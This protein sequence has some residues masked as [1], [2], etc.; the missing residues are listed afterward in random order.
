MTPEFSLVFSYDGIALLQ[1]APHGWGRV[2]TV[3]LDSA[4]ITADL[5]ALRAA[6]GGAGATRVKL[7]LPNDQIRYLKLDRTDATAA[8]VRA[9]LEGVTPYAVSELEY[10][11]QPDATGTHVAAVARDT[12]R[13]AE[14]FARDQGFQPLCFAAAA[15]DDSFTREVFFGLTAEGRVLCPGLGPD[16]APVGETGPRPEPAP[17]AAPPPAPRP[18]A[19][20]EALTPSEPA[21]LV[22]FRSRARPAP[23]HD[24]PPP[25][26]LPEDENGQPLFA[27]GPRRTA[28]MATRSDPAATG[29]TQQP[30]PAPPRNDPGPRPGAAAPRRSAPE[31][32]AT[33][34][35]QPAP[36]RPG[37]DLSAPPPPMPQRP[38]WPVPALLAAG[39]IAALAA[40]AWLWPDSP[41]PA[42]P[43]DMPATAPAPEPEAEAPP[44]VLP[45]PPITPTILT[46]DEARRLYA[47]TGVWQKAPPAPQS[48]PADRPASTPSAPDAAEV[49]RSASAA[50]AAPAADGPPAEPAPPPPY[51][52]RYAL[53]DRG[54]VIATPEGTLTPSGAVVYAGA[55][56]VSPPTRPGTQPPQTPTPETTPETAPPRVDGDTLT[57][58]TTAPN[59]P[60]PDEPAPDPAI[61]TAEPAAPAATSLPLNA[62]GLDLDG[63]RPRARPQDAPAPTPTPAATGFDGPTP[64]ARPGD[65][66]PDQPAPAPAQEGE[67]E[68]DDQAA[69]PVTIPDPFAGAT[70][71]AVLTSLRPDARPRGF[72]RT[73]ERARAAQAAAPV[74]A[75]VRTVRPSA[76]TSGSVA[77]NATQANVLNLR[78]ISLIGVYGSQ[79]D[80]RAHVRLGNGRI[81][82]VRPGDRLDGGRVAAIGT[83]ELVY[84]KNG[85]NIRLAMP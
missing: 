67:G 17:A 80:R 32:S 46:S 35:A 27:H 22:A 12:L 14:N 23:P 28:P 1:R 79:R 39:T 63:L 13:E 10:D 69:A 42:P 45:A 34:P 49:T 5:A 37:A 41:A 83:S 54:L 26:D 44:Q 38:K 70:Q 20:Q 19:A 11:F 9:A 64:R 3:P 53:D 55:P 6:A 50:S 7:V 77:G 16:D 33:L 78:A 66:A 24:T 18:D 73:V 59:R 72:A 68:G 61:P 56:P 40:A 51:D 52:S 57:L 71:L 62:A 30:R 84:T 74:S 36:A 82:T 15:H 21:P 85:R 31:L 48:P 75:T 4:D 81:V 25:S 65:L 2:G 60:A 47:A 8:D 58:L 76:P 29:P 43:P